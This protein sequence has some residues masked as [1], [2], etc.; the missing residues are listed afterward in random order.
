MSIKDVI[1]HE[2]QF[3]KAEMKSEASGVQIDMLPAMNCLVAAFGLIAA[4]IWKNDL[5]WIGIGA[6]LAAAAFALGR[7]D[8]KLTYSFIGLGLFVTVIG[9]ILSWNIPNFAA[10]GLIIGIGTFITIYAELLVTAAMTRYEAMVHRRD[11]ADEPS[12]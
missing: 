8:G 4:G 6:P 3:L 11:A 1:K 5:N 10:T 12:E 2:L 7:K 9:A